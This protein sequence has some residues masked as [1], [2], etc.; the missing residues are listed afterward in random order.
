MFRKLTLTLAALASL[1]IA[2]LAP[3]GA[4]AG[5][6]WHPHKHHHF[7]WKG[8]FGPGYGFYGIGYAPECYVVRKHTPWGV[9]FR[10]ICY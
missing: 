9:K 2:G 8:H 10:R 7:G 3:T 1:G 5:H 4:S 6:K